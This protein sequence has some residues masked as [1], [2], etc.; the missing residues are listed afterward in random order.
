MALTIAHTWAMPKVSA[1]TSPPHRGQSSMRLGWAL[2]IVCCP[3]TVSYDTASK[4]KIFAFVCVEKYHELIVVFV[5]F[6]VAAVYVTAVFV[7]AADATTIIVVV[8]T[9][10]VVA[11]AVAASFP[12]RPTPA[13]PPLVALSLS[14]LDRWRLLPRL[15]WS[16]EMWINVAFSARLVMRKVYV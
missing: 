10:A 11:V 16:T 7:A 9:V 4:C 12:P 6:V 14:S 13:P 5:V 15:E 8:V 1:L 3:L 2:P